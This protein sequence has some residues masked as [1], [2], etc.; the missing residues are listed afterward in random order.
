MPDYRRASCALFLLALAVLLLEVALTR[1]FSVM[2]WHHFVYLIVSLALL[3]FGVA[4]TY[5]TV[6]PRFAGEG[7]DESLVSRYS[8]AF[9][10]S[11]ICGFAAATKVRFQPMDIFRGDL[12]NVFSLLMLY[13]FVG[14]PFFF[15]GVCI[16]YLISRAGP[17]INQ[18]YF[19]DLLGAGTGA[20]LSVL[21]I[22]RLGAEAT[23][24]ASG[25]MGGVVTVLYARKGRCG[26]PLRWGG[27][28]LLVLSLVLMLLAARKEVFP[29]YFQPEKEIAPR[30]AEPHF[31]DWHVV[32]RIDVLEPGPFIS[33]FGGVISTQCDPN[34]RRVPTRAVFQD[35]SAPTGIVHVPGGDVSRIGALGYYL[36]GAPYVVRS[37]PDRTLV[38][39]VGGGVDVLIAL[40]HGAR[41]VVG[42]ELNPIIVE[43]VRTRYADFAGYVFNRPDVELI[44]GEGRHYVTAT[45]Q[46][47]DV[48][49]LSGV[50]SFAALSSGAYALSENYLYTVEA[51]HDYW[52]RLA[53]DGLLSFSRLTNEPPRETLRLV[54]I[55][56]QAMS[57]LNVPRPQRHLMV[58]GATSD[59]HGWAETLAKK[60]EFTEA[61]VAA[62]N[63]WADRM[64]FTV[65]YD[66]YRTL[67]NP[68][69]QLIRS[70]GNDR[71]R[72]IAKY[73]YNIRPI[74]D[75]DPFFFQFARWQSLWD[76]HRGVP[77]GE[78]NLPVGLVILL[79]TLIQ[80]TVLSGALII[81]PLWSRVSH[82]RDVE[83]KPRVLTYFACLGLGFIL[84]EIG[85]LQKFTV[86][87]GGPVYAMSITLFAI[88]VFSGLGSLV[89]RRIG[90]VLPGGPSTVLVMVVGLIVGELLFVNLAVPRLMF[91]SH[92]AR[93]M[94]TVLAL[95]PLAMAM[96]MPFPMGLGIA[97]RLGREIVPWVWGVNAVST[98]LGAIVC[99]LIS[100][101]FGF[102]AAI[103]VAVLAYV[104]A[105]VMG[106]HQF[107]PGVPTREGPA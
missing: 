48:I 66:P 104:L 40:Y 106:I 61:E 13:V 6:S 37:K 8:L 17:R 100:M 90:D 18:Y 35:G 60:S 93:C 39:G 4:G 69:D 24:Y 83:H 41:H 103:T 31:F 47:F 86:F 101:A 80:M 20:L 57:E 21:L 42:V 2:M 79:I 88:L 55:L 74:S 19:S 26:R 84:A 33:N 11:C 76:R 44:A 49:Q 91:L 87:V 67:G 97:G 92:G 58:I 64:G 30:A 9:C 23:V 25:V 36:Q 53:P 68:Y 22:N 107:D 52:K 96:G 7:I 78:W 72:M 95:A 51:M 43:A 1:V 82:L 94:V 46:L 12:T 10:A 63:K 89:S 5:L 105:A 71:F 27:R 32:A 102:T 34:F 50:D 70:S 75:D 28:G 45:R 54:S 15:A 62:C 16:G 98:T 99:I 77:A 85:L 38:I 14:V 29:L 3:G 56:V 73:P 65:L 81:G 59:G